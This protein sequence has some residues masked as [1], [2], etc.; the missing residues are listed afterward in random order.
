MATALTPSVVSLKPDITYG[1]TAEGGGGDRGNVEEEAHG[2]TL[3]TS[4]GMKVV[5]ELTWVGGGRRV[6][7][8]AQPATW[9][10]RESTSFG[11]GG[12]PASS[13]SKSPKRMPRHTMG[14]CQRICWPRSSGRRKP[15]TSRLAL[16]GNITSPQR[17]TQ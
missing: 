13:T 10:T 15:S 2:T 16:N 9:K 7:R 17:S 1:A 4:Q 12:Q 11:R 8:E 5:P 14:W 6:S 3:E